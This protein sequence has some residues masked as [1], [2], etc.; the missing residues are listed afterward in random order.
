MSDTTIQSGRANDS[1]APIAHIYSSQP[2]PQMV[3]LALRPS[4]LTSR[5]IED[6]L[7]LEFVWKG[8]CDLG[9]C[10]MMK[11]NRYCPSSRLYSSASNV[12]V[13][14]HR[15]RLSTRAVWINDF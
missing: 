12:C 11:T 2:N 6:M 10:Q 13:R 3:K 1:T 15:W 7:S 8:S 4:G 9:G 14:W 5:S